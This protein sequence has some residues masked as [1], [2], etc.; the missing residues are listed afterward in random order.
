[1]THIAQTQSDGGG[2]AH[3]LA[4]ENDPFP[5]LL[6][7]IFEPAVD[8][9]Q[10]NGFAAFLSIELHDFDGWIARA[11]AAAGTLYPARVVLIDLRTGLGRTVAK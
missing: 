1:M 2:P 7:V 10:V 9:E 6:Q 11:R 5:R 8:P 4:V 3:V